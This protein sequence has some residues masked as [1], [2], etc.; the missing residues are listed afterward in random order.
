MLRNFDPFLQFTG[1]YVPELQSFFANVT[2][3]TEAHDKNYDISN[4]Q[5]QHYLRGLVTINPESLAV[6]SQR[7][8]TNRANPYFQP[9]ALR[10]LGNGGLQVFSTR[11]LRQLRPVG[12]RARERRGVSRASSNS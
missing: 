1:D 3:A 6:Y 7:I 12:Q 8:G 11:G 2:A 4:G 9:G 10:A 5:I